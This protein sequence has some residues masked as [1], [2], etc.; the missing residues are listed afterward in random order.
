MADAEDPVRDVIEGGEHKAWSRYS[1]FTGLV[2]EGNCLDDLDAP[3]HSSLS[4]SLFDSN[5]HKQLLNL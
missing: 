2:A 4:S 3:T 5:R 1:D